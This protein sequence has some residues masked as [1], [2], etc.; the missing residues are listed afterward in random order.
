[1]LGASETKMTLPP[2][3]CPECGQEYLHSVAVC[4]DCGVALVLEREPIAAVELPPASALRLVRTATLSWSRSFSARLVEAGIAHR[5]E[6]EPDADGSALATRGERLASVFVREGDVAE[7]AR[8][9]AEHLRRQIPDVPEDFG[10]A[11]PQQD[12]CPACGESAD[13]AA[14]ECASCGLAFNDA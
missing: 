6:L 13:L 4:A 11:A 14:A 1:M 12:L 5:V 10:L 2:K 9:D 3:H 7:A 8:L